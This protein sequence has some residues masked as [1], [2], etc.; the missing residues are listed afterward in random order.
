[1]KKAFLLGGLSLILVLGSSVA[2]AQTVT[3]PAEHPSLMRGVRPIGMGNAFI[4]MPGTD[5]NA[6][7]YNPDA[8]NDYEKQLHFKFISPTVDL[9]PEA[10][11]R[12]RTLSPT[13]IMPPGM[14]GVS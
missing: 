7:F 14:Q 3:I 9:S 8:I 11:L 4:A 5:E 2:W 10:L 1:M 13:S 12:S 6:P